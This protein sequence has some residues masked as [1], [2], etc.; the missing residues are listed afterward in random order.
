MYAIR[1]YYVYV[2]QDGVRPPSLVVF[3]N[4][5]EGVHFSYQRYLSNKF[6]EAF[7]LTGTPLR[8]FYKDRERNG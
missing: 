5:A 7:G 6:R 1:S 8:I 2:T 3:V 4:R